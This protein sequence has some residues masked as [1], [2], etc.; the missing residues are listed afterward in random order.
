[1]FIKAGTLTS[2]MSQAALGR[3]DSYIGC[4]GEI[5]QGVGIWNPGSLGMEPGFQVSAVPHP[6]ETAEP[7]SI[8]ASFKHSKADPCLGNRLVRVRLN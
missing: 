2:A 1:M 7:G 8:G 5:F 3:G 4:F 6:Q